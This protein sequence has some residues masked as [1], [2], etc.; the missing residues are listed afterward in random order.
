M[1]SSWPQVAFGKM[2]EEY[3]DSGVDRSVKGSNGGRRGVKAE[4]LKDHLTSLTNFYE[5][6]SHANANI[7]YSQIPVWDIHMQI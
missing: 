6:A 7:L 1:A 2:G 4:M 5:V 3:G